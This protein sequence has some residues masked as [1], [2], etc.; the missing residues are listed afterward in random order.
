[1]KAFED[2]LAEMVEANEKMKQVMALTEMPE[3]EPNNNE[4][5]NTEN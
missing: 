5:E 2:C 4:D 1:M 3:V